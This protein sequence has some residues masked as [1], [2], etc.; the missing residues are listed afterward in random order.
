MAV[1][2]KS[3]RKVIP[4]ERMCMGR[5]FQVGGAETEKACDE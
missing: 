2:L 1:K 3:K 4:V 5:V